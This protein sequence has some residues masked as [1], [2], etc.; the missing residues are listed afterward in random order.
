M[1]ICPSCHRKMTAPRAA[2]G[3]KKFEIDCQRAQ[4]A[5]EVCQSYLDRHP[6]EHPAQRESVRLEMERMQRAQNNP[7]LLWAIYRRADKD[8]GGYGVVTPERRVA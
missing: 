8:G 7:T 1:N 3:A 6:T 5:V 2:K 4:Y